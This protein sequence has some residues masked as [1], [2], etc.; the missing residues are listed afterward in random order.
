MAAIS[1]E[2]QQISDQLTAKSTQFVTNSSQLE[3]SV[4]NKGVRPPGPMGRAQWAQ[5]D[6]PMS[7][8]HAPGPWDWRLGPM[9]R[10]HGVGPGSRDLY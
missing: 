5:W 1:N 4:A 6:E 7:R 2:Q 9:G 10:A 3:Q 8:A